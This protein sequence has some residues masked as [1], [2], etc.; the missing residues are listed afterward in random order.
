MILQH[1]ALQNFRSYARLD[2]DFQPGITILSGGNAQGKTSLLESLFYCATFAPLIARN[3]RQLINFDAQRSADPAPVVARIVI[4]FNRGD[5]DER[6]EVR[7]IQDAPE[8]PTR[9]RKEI[10]L[11][12]QKT[13]AQK[14]IGKFPAV[15]FIPQMTAILEGTPHERRRYLNILLSQSVSDYAQT[16]TDYQ[17]ILVQRNAL[18]RQIAEGRANAMQ[19]DYWDEMLAERGASLI[20]HRFQALKTLNDYAEDVHLKLT[21]QLEKISLVYNPSFYPANPERNNESPASTDMTE[22]PGT[23][24]ITRLLKQHLRTI[25]SREIDRGITTVGPHRDDFQMT[26]N[27]ID[28]GLFGSRGQIRTAL[29]SLKFAEIRW[30]AEKTATEP[31]LLLDETLAELDGKRR[32]DLLDRLDSCSQ[33]ILTTTDLTHFSE[34]F[35]KRHTVW[36]VSNGVIRPL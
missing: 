1:L 17:K 10:L 30:I 18:L 4:A 19:L 24:E 2:V 20:E 5:H 31:L 23:N 9:T 22:S 14:A 3:D 13:N 12:G 21:D 15:L 25:R 26:A 27:E 7:I 36:N 6:M 8:N 34:S 29:L 35:V 11:N 33:G 32:Q 16:L 28:L